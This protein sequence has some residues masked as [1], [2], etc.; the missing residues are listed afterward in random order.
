M[1]LIILQEHEKLGNK[2]FSLQGRKKQHLIENLKAR[3]GDSFQAGILNQSFGT[4]KVLEIQ[5]SEVIV[6]FTENYYFP[7]FTPNIQ[8]FSSFQR[9]Q[10]TKKILQ[11]SACVGIKEISFFLLDKTEKSYQTSKLWKQ[12]L[13]EEEFLLG[14]EQGKRIQMPKLNLYF[15]SKEKISFNFS[16]HTFLL[17]LEGKSFLEYIPISKDSTFSFILGPESGIT[18]KDRE[19]FIQKGAKPLKLSHNV[20]RSE[21][22]LAFAISQL[23]LVL[24]LGDKNV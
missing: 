19:F 17:D 9:P 5:N 14:L 1:N 21:F 3:V 18:S 8:I 10:T 13:W 6:Q 7:Y 11:L 2:I 15:T 4:I 12:N 16:T 24:E 20:L 23:E 22:A